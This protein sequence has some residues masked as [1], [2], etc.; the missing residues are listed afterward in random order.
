MLRCGAATVVFWVVFNSQFRFHRFLFWLN[1]TARFIHARADFS[2]AASLSAGCQPW[3]GWLWCCGRCRWC[4]VCLNVTFSLQR[5]YFTAGNCCWTT[6]TLIN[7]WRTAPRIADI[8]LIQISSF[9]QSDSFSRFVF[10]SFLCDATW[11]NIVYRTGI[12]IV[13]SLCRCWNRHALETIHCCGETNQ[14]A[15][16]TQTSFSKANYYFL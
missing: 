11:W 9:A 2:S 7:L 14:E 4:K 13:L 1:S 16:C 5:Y 3:N 12:S 10:Y 15:G 8:I 6:Q